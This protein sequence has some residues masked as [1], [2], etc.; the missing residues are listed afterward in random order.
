VKCRI[1]NVSIPENRGMAM[2]G[3]VND[4][5]QELSGRRIVCV[6]EAR[7]ASGTGDAVLRVLTEEVE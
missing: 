5:S 7:P 3:T 4:A 2:P 1:E 6:L